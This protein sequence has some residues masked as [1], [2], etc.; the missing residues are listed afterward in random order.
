[1]SFGVKKAI[2]YLAISFDIISAVILGRNVC[3]F[4]FRY[5]FGFSFTVPCIYITIGGFTMFSKEN[6]VLKNAI[7]RSVKTMIQQES[8]DWPPKCG[9]LLYQPLRPKKKTTP[10]EKD[11]SK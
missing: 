8:D 4:I 7:K 2:S 11:N 9:I 10:A 5:C 1:M 3:R 6:A